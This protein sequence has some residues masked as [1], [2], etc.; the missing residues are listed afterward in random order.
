MSTLNE[1]PSVPSSS[2]VT[3]QG[4]GQ[5]DNGVE[6][7]KN[8]WVRT[9]CHGKRNAKPFFISAWNVRTLLDRGTNRPERRTA[10]VARELE[11]YKVD[12]AALS[13]TR[14]LGE[15]QCTEVGAGYTFYWSGRGEGERRQAG[16]GFAVKTSLVTTLDSLPQ[17]INDRLMKMRLPLTE[18]KYVTLISAY[19]PTMNNPDETKE[20]FY[21]QLNDTILSVHKSDKLILLGDFN[22]RIGA[23]HTVWPNVIGHHGIGKENSNGKL[24]LTLCAQ[25]NLCVTNTYFQLKEKYKTTWMHPRS[26]HWHQ[27]DFAICRRHDLKDFKITRVMRGAE[28]STDHRLIR[29]K[30]TFQVR[31]KRRPQGKKP[32]KKLDVSQLQNPTVA[33]EFQNKLSEKLGNLSFSSSNTDIDENWTKLRDTMMA[34][35]EATIGVMKKVH[36]DW[37]DDN[38]LEIKELLAEKY[39][40]H[41]SWLAEE[42]SDAKHRLFLSLRSK[43]QSRLRAMKDEW[44][45]KKAEEIQWYADTKN[46][47]LFYAGIKT[48]FGPRQGS[49]APVKNEDGDILTDNVA[50]NKRWAEHFEQLLNRQ[51]AIDPSVIDDIP[52]RTIRHDLDS[53][54][55]RCEVVR[56]ISQLQTGKAAGPD[57]I[58]PEVLKA[59]GDCLSNKLTEFFGLC[60]ND[61]CLPQDMKDARIVHLYKGKGEKSSCDNHRGI[62]LLSIAGKILAKIILNRLNDHFVD[63]IVPESQCGFRKNRGTADMIFAARQ[64][65]E[66]CHEQNKDLYVLFVDLTKAFDTVSRPGLWSMLPR[67]GIPP[68]MMQMIRSFHDGMKA[69]V[70]GSDDGNEFEVTNG[71]KQGCVLAPTLFSFLF[72]LML[73]SAFKNTDPAVDLRYRTDSGLFNIQA[74]KAKTKVTNALLRELMYADDCAIVAHSEEDLQSLT[75]ALSTATKKFGLTISIKKTEVMYQPARGSDSNPPLITIDGNALKNVDKFTYLGSCLS[76]ANSLDDEL[77]SRLAKASSSFGRLTDRVWNERGLKLETKIAVYRA[78]VL[79]ALLYGCESWTVYRRQIK[80]LEQFHQR[81]LRR[82]LNIKW[83]D[84][85]SNVTVLQR[86][87]LPSI[88]T[89]LLQTQLRWA[90]HVVRMEDNRIPKQLFYGELSTGCR[91]RGRPKLRYKDTLKRALKATDMNI[92]EWEVLARNRG[93]WRSQIHTLAVRYEDERQSAAINARAARKERIK[94]TAPTIPCPE[95]GFLCRSTFGLRSHSRIHKS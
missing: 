57:G 30:L 32:P 12:I 84:R 8:L 44:W 40:A 62:S 17:A 86:T 33:A 27:I 38:D 70:V 75:D 15:G 45:R 88:E 74:L 22:A 63:E 76:S 67:I 64:L 90:G 13:E 1:R 20:T 37:F 34:E 24:L 14:L 5:T 47:K 95:C 79:S 92:S 82:V 85:I 41:K 50:I 56:A 49:S 60:W 87:K 73:F 28:C 16:V 36:Q 68:K 26:K 4:S 11:R 52:Q 48:V 72:S 93:T 2:R 81:H 31:R 78:V 59:G 61:G 35:A 71:V 51:S 42:T 43:L 46:T 9:G 29:C 19:A 18:G 65:Q 6:G 10:L 91:Q 83:Q 21:Q 77:S 23:D 69:K 39:V 58:P 55:S 80:M 3:V 94:T 66:K 7:A 25:H 53:P 89:I 54:P